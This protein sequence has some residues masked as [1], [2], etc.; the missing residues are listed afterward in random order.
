MITEAETKADAEVML[1]LDFLINDSVFYHLVTE[2]DNSNYN[3]SQPY[4]SF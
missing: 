1:I 3:C 2:D 4:I